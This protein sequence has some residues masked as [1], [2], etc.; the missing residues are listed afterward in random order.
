[1]RLWIETWVS[2]YL[3]AD[4]IKSVEKKYIGTLKTSQG[5]FIYV[6]IVVCEIVFGYILLALTGSLNKNTKKQL[7]EQSGYELCATEEALPNSMRAG[8]E[9]DRRIY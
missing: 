7:I 5:F 4:S 9:N 1:M 3:L 6:V 8:L 2:S